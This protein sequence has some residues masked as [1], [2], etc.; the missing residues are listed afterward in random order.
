MNT[1]ETII[2][3]LKSKNDVN[4]V[5]LVGSYAVGEQKPYSDLDLVIILNRNIKKIRS[6]FTWIDSIFADIYF[7]DITDL[8]RISKTS[9]SPANSTDAIFV[10]W[11]KA[12]NIQFDKS[13]KTTIL[14][15][16]LENIQIIVP[17]DE[18][19]S[20]W[21]KINYNYIAN[22][23]YYESGDP[24]Y[25]DALNIRLLYSVA[26]LLTGYFSLR[27]LQWRGEKN[28]V[29]HFREHDE[30]F[31]NNFINFTKATTIKEK[32]EAYNHMVMRVLP[33]N[34][35]LWSKND[36]I[37]IPSE[38]TVPGEQSELIKYWKDLTDHDNN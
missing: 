24:L 37:A 18:Q 10:S 7:F 2:K 5:F 38:A 13:N 14:R 35:K 8:E 25:H 20:S 4:A 17:K 3:N 12:G 11:L 36:V 26:E 31:F 27:G 19:W 6:I 30:D 16:N 22:K 32:F 21:Q 29:K 9:S 1:L 33:G 15:A 23:R 34:Y 28:A